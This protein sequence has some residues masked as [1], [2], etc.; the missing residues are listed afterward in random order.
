ME[1]PKLIIANAAAWAASLSVTPIAPGMSAAAMLN[2]TKSHVCRATGTDMEIVL[3]W[4]VAVQIGGAWLLC[5]GSP[6][7][8]IQLLGYSDKAGA[9][10]VF[11]TEAR[12]A[13]PA[14]SRQLRHPWTPAQAASAYAWGGGALAGT[15]CDN[16]SVK[17]LVIR[18]ADPGNL[19][20]YFEV[21]RVLTGESFTL[22]CGSSFD[23]ALTPIDNSTKTRT[24]AGDE[25]GVKGTKSFKLALP[26]NH[27]TERDR[28]FLWDMLIAN[29]I[30]E[31]SFID[32]YP[33]DPS[34]ER[35][36][37]HRMIGS[38]VQTTAMRRPNFI[39]HATS[40]EWQSI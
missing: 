39:Y 15:W 35:A 2:N 7:T 4:D 9:N 26:L 21:A 31:F 19:Q 37:D 36:R 11:D 33:G 27:V 25:R 16:T 40:L 18:L 17:R 28:E 1:N 30:T 10:Q 23:P 13:C 14:R 34:A 22:D 38:L 20:G 12:L 8:S 24:D 3:T 32:Q 29:G 5:N 6:L